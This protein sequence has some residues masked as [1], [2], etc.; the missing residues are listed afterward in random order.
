VGRTNGS[1]AHG[2]AIIYLGDNPA[3]FEAEFQQYGAIVVRQTGQ[4]NG[5]AQTRFVLRSKPAA[6]WQV[7]LARLPFARVGACETCDFRMAS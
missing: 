6:Q 3:A 1:P 5:T 2:Q 7:L 4:P